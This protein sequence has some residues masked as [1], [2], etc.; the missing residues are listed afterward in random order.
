MFA[1][2]GP[3]QDIATVRIAILVGAIALVV[4]WR[5][6]LRLLI[7]ILAIA[8]ITLLGAGAFELLQATHA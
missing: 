3:H 4:Y 1:A 6:A 7:M 8:A 2:K 5:L